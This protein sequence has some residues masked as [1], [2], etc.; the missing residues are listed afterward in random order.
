MK[1]IIGVFC[2]LLIFSLPL[3]SEE[4]QSQVTRI[5]DGDTIYLSAP[6]REL[7]IRLAG[8]DAP[9]SNQPYGSESRTALAQMLNGKTV[10]VI[11]IDRDR[12]GRIVGRVYLGNLDINLEMIRKGYAWVYRHYNSDQNF[13]STEAEAKNARRGLWGDN[14]KPI[15]PWK[16]RFQERTNY[17]P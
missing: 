16:W 3:H 14:N 4:Y 11:A 8:I 13:Y 15:P 17:L 1:I 7:K 10:R 9:E 12:Y 2:T 6:G 5:I